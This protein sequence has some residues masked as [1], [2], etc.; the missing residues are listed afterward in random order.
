MSTN[1][2]EFSVRLKISIMYI[3]I[4][5]I[6]TYICIE[7]A[8]TYICIEYASMYIYIEYASTY[9]SIE[10]ASKYTCS[11]LNTLKLV[12]AKLDLFEIAKFNTLN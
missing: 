6:G 10:Y 2:S 12:H 5:Y 4:E 9:I 1:F 7:Y 8:S 3:C 11:P